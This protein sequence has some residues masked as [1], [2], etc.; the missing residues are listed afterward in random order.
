MP[1]RQSTAAAIAMS[2]KPKSPK[3]MSREPKSRKPESADAAETGPQLP[4]R[5]YVHLIEL[6]SDSQRTRSR[7]LRALGLG[8][9][10]AD[11]PLATVSLAGI[12][13][14]LALLRRRGLPAAFGLALGRAIE[15]EEHHLLGHAL[16]QART[17]GD[18]LQLAA[19]YFAL[20]SPG[21]R[22]RLQPGS[23]RAR[24]EVIPWL[25]FSPQTLALH[26]DVVLAALWRM[27][28]A[29]SDAPLPPCDVRV[30]WARPTH[31]SGYAALR[32]WRIRFESAAHPGFEL[33]LP[34]D[35]LQTA[36]ARAEPA[37]LA[38]V[39]AR[40]RSA[41][42]GICRSSRLGDW[43]GMM[44]R[45]QG[46]AA[47]MG[48]IAELAG[49]SDR[50][51]CRRLGKEGRSFRAESLQA[52]MQRACRALEEGAAVGDVAQQ[53]GYSDAANFARA[54]RRC[55]D[56]PPSRHRRRSGAA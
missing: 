14:T 48:E 40:C 53:C 36:R 26:L 27:L 2:P 7:A 41:I 33:D 10:G 52:R 51:L 17:V 19:R 22:L 3:P 18:A 47:G 12:E 5:Y 49:M 23:A 25:P 4:A 46:T 43:V 35:W 56:Y 50:T 11:D 54:F 9:G 55:F 15:P 8:H 39:E 20:L 1:S 6:A 30:A 37:R 29:L 34:A 28:G 42:Q 31:A 16:L 13:R 24:I 45:A 38:E 32:P 44:V 21:F